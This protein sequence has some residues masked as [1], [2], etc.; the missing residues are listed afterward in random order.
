MP[1]PDLGNL[2]GELARGGV[3]AIITGFAYPS[4]AG[5]AMHPGQCGIDTDDKIAPWRR[6]V[7]RVRATAPETKL[8]LQISHAGRQTRSAATGQPVVGA[9]SRRCSYFRQ[10]VQA[11]DDDGIR[12]IINEYAL[13]ARRAREA[14]FDG[15]QVHAAHGYLVHQ[16]LSRWTNTRHDHWAEP[17]AFLEEITRA[18]RREC[19]DDYPVLVKLSAADD[20]T[21]GL[22]LEDTIRTVKRLEEHAVDAV[23]ISY[24]TMEYALNIIRGALPIQVAFKENP[25]FNRIPAPVQ[26]LWKFCCFPAYRRQ[27]IP[28]NEDYNVPA[29]VQIAEETSLPVIPVGGIRTLESMLACLTT[30]D[31]PAVSLCRPL[32]CEPD[33]VEKIRAGA[34]ERSACTNCNLCTMHCDGSQPL[35]CHRV[36]S[37]TRVE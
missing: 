8:I 34:W 15:V 32:V 10:S 3:G 21:P 11:L 16:F 37:L 13:A 25:L 18:I 35:R 19:G 2:Y 23:E 22:R 36:R 29:A 26:R 31:L 14:G 9:S 7:E 24:G 33:L 6:I 28:F 4:R 20:R 30:H 12:R 5:R 1:H 17:T 27:F